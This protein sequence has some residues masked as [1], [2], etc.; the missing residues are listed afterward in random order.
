LKN[1]ILN[2]DDFAMNAAVSRGIIN[3]ARL[4]RLTATSA[5]TL[6]PRWQ[7]DAMAL[8]ESNAQIDVGLHLDW[9]SPFAV[10]KG[11][12]LSL[13]RGV[14]I[15][16]LGGYNKST[17]RAV[18]EEQLDVFEQVWQA[19]PSHI[20]GHQHVHQFRGIRDALV[21]VINKRYG[22]LP[23]TQKPYLRVSEDPSNR[24][25]F[26]SRIIASM[27]ADALKNTATQADIMLARGLFGVYNFTGGESAYA[28]RMSQWLCDAPAG[29]IIMCHPAQ[30]SIEKGDADDGI[31]RAR[32]WEYDYLASECFTQDL[33]NHAVIT[34]INSNE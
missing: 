10:A 5:M 11:H 7:Q 22:H 26:K 15:A 6:S 31:I 8:R 16:A 24:F 23:K 32:R 17:A 21:E 3:L 27:N 29:S 28:Q 9:T 20:D 30:G 2:A 1:I 18:I 4:G 34:R 13:K 33:I 19:V 14:L 25:N 12:G